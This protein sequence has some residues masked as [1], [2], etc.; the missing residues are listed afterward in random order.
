MFTLEKKSTTLATP[1]SP[2]H[3]RM[4]VA[5]NVTGNT[6]TLTDGASKLKQYFDSHVSTV[7]GVSHAD[8]NKRM[9]SGTSGTTNFTCSDTN[10]MTLTTGT[11]D[12]SLV[13]VEFEYDG[14]TNYVIT[15]IENSTSFRVSP[16]HSTTITMGQSLIEV[17]QATYA[18]D[19]GFIEVSGLTASGDNRLYKVSSYTDT[20]LTLADMAGNNPNMATENGVTIT[21]TTFTPRDRLFVGLD[22][23]NTGGDADDYITKWVTN[24][25]AVNEPAVYSTLANNIIPHRAYH[26]TE[27]KV[28]YGSM[29]TVVAKFHDI[30]DIVSEFKPLPPELKD[31]RGA[32]CEHVASTAS[33]GTVGYS[34]FGTGT[35][36]TQ[37]WNKGVY[38]DYP[39]VSSTPQGIISDNYNVHATS[40]GTRHAEK[41]IWWRNFL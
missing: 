17:I 38:I 34:S 9:F 26:E 27:L 3:F 18:D 40:S 25:N 6:I 36:S 5:A 24:I 4:Q 32:I 33:I 12:P 39:N 31:A 7:I 8:N 29:D 41:N 21:L 14:G 19:E 13:G 10:L 20:V 2:G 30:M 37:H 15:K 28:D 11:T 22:G 23:S 35:S 1:A 16:N